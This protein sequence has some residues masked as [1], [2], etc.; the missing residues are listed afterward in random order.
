MN[1]RN[2][3]QLVLGILLILAAA[4]LVIGQ[5]RPEWTNWLHLNFEWPMWILLA[6][7]ALL[8]IG[9][10]TGNPEMAVPACIVAGVGGILYYQNASGDW[11]S[12]S[13]MWTL[14]P[15]FGGLGS[16]LSAAIAGRLKQE[17]R[18]AI[19][20]IFVSLILFAIFGTIFGG[21]EFLGA[22]KDYAIIGILFLIGLWLIL[23]GIFRKRE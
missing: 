15:G 12:W 20:T 9:L 21:L 6:G 16:L 19:N 2:R 18:S 3:T 1:K 7:A 4:W 8:L 13:Y 10:L 23:R 14:I 5:V 17:A 22:Y 11:T